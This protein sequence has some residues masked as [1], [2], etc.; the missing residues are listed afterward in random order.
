MAGPLGVG[1]SVFCGQWFGIA[2]SGAI[3]TADGRFTRRPVAGRAGIGHE[4]TSRGSQVTMPGK[5]TTRAM[6]ASSAKKNGI[7]PRTSTPKG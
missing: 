6:T 3:R 2:K 1:I 5:A 4:K 7:A